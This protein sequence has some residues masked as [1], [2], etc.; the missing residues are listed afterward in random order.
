MSYNLTSETY[1]KKLIIHEIGSIWVPVPR[2]ESWLIISAWHRGKQVVYWYHLADRREKKKELKAPGV[3]SSRISFGPSLVVGQIMS[4]AFQA[5]E[6]GEELV[7]F[8]RPSWC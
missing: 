8:K 5:L 1:Y 4:G 6:P 7:A 2:I 3:F